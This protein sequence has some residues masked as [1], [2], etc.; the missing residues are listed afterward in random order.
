MRLKYFLEQLKTVNRIPNDYLSKVIE[1]IG[2]PEFGGMTS[3][4]ILMVLNIAVKAMENDETF[5]ELGTHRGLTLCGAMLHNEDKNFIAID[6]FSQ[7]GGNTGHLFTNLSMIFP[8]GLP[9]HF[10]FKAQ[11][12]ETAFASDPINNIGVCFFDALH[13]KDAVLRY[14]ELIYPYLSRDALLIFDDAARFQKDLPEWVGEV[15][16]ATEQILASYSDKGIREI[17]YYGQPKEKGWH[18][19]LRIFEYHAAN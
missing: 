7:Y 2:T 4:N 5:V 15:W 16:E 17:G 1:K 10:K 8:D 3:A 12:I 19:G 13:T 14:F 11:S 18:L 9:A 6:D